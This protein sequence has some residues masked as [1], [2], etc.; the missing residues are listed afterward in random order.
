LGFLTHEDGTDRLSRNVLRSY[1]NSLRKNPEE[2]SC[3]GKVMLKWML[4][5]TMWPGFNRLR[6]E[7]VVVS[8]ERY[9]ESSGVT[10]GTQC[11]AAAH[12]CAAPLTALAT[13]LTAASHDAVNSFFV[14]SFPSGS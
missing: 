2:G 14:I 3:H 7:L 12:C 5:V 13:E 10:E 8:F 9:N 1:H 4:S 6:M 11:G